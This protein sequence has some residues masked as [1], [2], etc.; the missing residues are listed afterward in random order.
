METLRVF[1]DGCLPGMRHVQPAGG[2][3]KV[4]AAATDPD[5][6]SPV[7]AF[8]GRAANEVL[9]DEVSE[10]EGSQTVE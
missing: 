3:A 4:V 8:I 10:Q 6:A 7:G 1:L 9:D 2:D 5:E